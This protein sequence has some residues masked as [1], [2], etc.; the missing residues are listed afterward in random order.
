MYHAKASFPAPLVL[1]HGRV[2]QK[3]EKPGGV[4][5]YS[6]YFSHLL[7]EFEDIQDFGRVVCCLWDCKFF[8][9][10]KHVRE[11]GIKNTRPRQRFSTKSCLDLPS[12]TQLPTQNQATER[13]STASLSTT[14]RPNAWTQSA[15]ALICHTYVSYPYHI[16]RR[17]FHDQYLENFSHER[18]KRNSVSF[19][20]WVIVGWA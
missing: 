14:L 8:S 7:R 15:A 9:R 6:S 11:N 1:V 10:S 17:R 4:I 18:E 2:P 16:K 19:Y 12:K 3:T 13:I 20:L 5:N